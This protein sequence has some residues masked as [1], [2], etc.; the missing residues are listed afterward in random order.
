METIDRVRFDNRLD[1][2]MNIFWRINEVEMP[3]VKMIQY[4][5]DVRLTFDM[6]TA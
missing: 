5:N 3:S 4:E 2:H 6:M 1:K